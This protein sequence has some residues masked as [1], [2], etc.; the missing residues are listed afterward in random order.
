MRLVKVILTLCASLVLL[1]SC[2][3]NSRMIQGIFDDANPATRQQWAYRDTGVWDPQR[4]TNEFIAMFPTYA[5]K[6]LE[7]V[8]VGLQGGAPRLTAQ[9]PE[10][11]TAFKPNGSLKSTWMYRLDRVITAAAEHHL[12]VDVSLFYFWQAHRVNTDAGIVR[13]VTNITDFLVRHGYTNVVVEICNECDNPHY[14]HANLRPTRV[15]SLIELVQERSAGTLATSA[16][17]SGGYIPPDSVITHADFV[18]LHGNGQSP[19]QITQ[20]VRTVKAK[21]AYRAHPTPII[22]N[23]DSTNLANM[24]AALA[25]GAGWGYYDQAGFQSPPVNWTI[26][27]PTK[28]AFFDHIP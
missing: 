1:A 10:N 16:S 27:T 19:G 7:M 28:R 12:K 3:V 21:A 24:D 5:A 8:T 18:T 11:V 14:T 26:N 4:N 22:F 9:H 6:G 25:A 23:E 20:M 15:W 13:A 2:N 17:F